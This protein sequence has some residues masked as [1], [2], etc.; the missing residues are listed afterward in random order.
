M[1]EGQIIVVSAPSGSGK[2]TVVNNLLSINP[3][4]SPSISYTSRPPRQNETEGVHY[5][6]VPKSRFEEMI[7]G[8]EFAEYDYYQ[9]DYYGTSAA[10]VEELLQ[11]G[12]DAVF[13]ITIKGACAVRERFPRAVLVFL[14]PPSFEE[15]ERRLRKRGTETD[16]K[17]K[18][19]LAEAKREIRSI[20]LFD[21]FVV[22]DD[23]AAAAE[24]LNCILVAEKCR[25][26]AQNDFQTIIIP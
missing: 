26:R 10:K 9:G 23:A 13:K 14:I 4:V 7:E 19:R 15:L 22:N 1:S 18:G 3:R 5:F 16:D 8:K 6:F 21:Y 20:G 25:V 11:S 17:I 24:R 12:R 2:D